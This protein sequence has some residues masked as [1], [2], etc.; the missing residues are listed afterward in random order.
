M[1]SCDLARNLIIINF[2]FNMSMNEHILSI[3]KPCFFK[4]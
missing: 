4:L 1:F 3:G 2:K